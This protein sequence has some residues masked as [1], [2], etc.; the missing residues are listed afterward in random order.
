MNNIRKIKR[1]INPFS[2]IWFCLKELTRKKLP[3]LINNHFGKRAPQ[4]KYTFGDAILGWL[5]CNL[6]GGDRLD[7]LNHMKSHFKALPNLKLPSHDSIGRI[8]KNLAT[9]NLKLASKNNVEHT[10]SYM[11]PCCR[12]LEVRKNHLLYYA[13][14]YH[15]S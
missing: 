14:F 6:C 13:F 11:L 9:E 5:Y 4:S 1:N 8:F 10:R 15:Q 2:G 12:H 7:D 3:E